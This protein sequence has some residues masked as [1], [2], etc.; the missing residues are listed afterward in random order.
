MSASRLTG[1]VG[2]LTLCSCS[3]I[4]GGHAPSTS[5]RNDHAAS[6]SH[7]EFQSSSEPSKEA[8]DAIGWGLQYCKD[9]LNEDRSINEAK[10]NYEKFKKRLD[11]AVSADASIRTWG[12][13]IRGMKVDEWIAKCE[14]EIPERITHDE[15]AMAAESRDNALS[16]E[17]RSSINGSGDWSH[18][19]QLKAEAIK[20]NKGPL[21]GEI[22]KLLAKCEV[23]YAAAVKAQKV[24]DAE[25]DAAFDRQMKENAERAKKA[26][27]AEKALRASLKQDRGRIYDRYGKP[28]NW[29]GDLDKT[30]EWSW[31]LEKTHLG[32]EASC[33]TF[34]R[35][36]GNKKVKEWQD[37]E[38][39]KWK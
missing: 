31:V 36:K 2:L 32:Y 24:H 7:S 27:L 35:F 17:C 25:R 11:T 6:Y 4:S 19:Q 16:I 21:T 39:C 29:D 14:K 5:P 20:A 12:G 13:Q 34:V 33:W 10:D 28:T 22:A 9:A 38:A 30:P 3:L 8:R 23:D 15:G 18:Y 1:L 37:G 26:E